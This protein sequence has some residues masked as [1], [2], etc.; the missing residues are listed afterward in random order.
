MN[1][2]GFEVLDSSPEGEE[3]RGAASALRLRGAQITLAAIAVGALLAGGIA[4]FAIAHQAKRQSAPKVPV[5]L[6]G[7][8]IPADVSTSDDSGPKVDGAGVIDMVD[9]ALINS[10]ASP[11]KNLSITWDDVHQAFTHPDEGRT[12]LQDLAPNAPQ[13]VR[14]LLRQPCTT[15][16]QP[17]ARA[18]PTVVINAS[19]PTGRTTTTT[20]TPLGLDKVWSAMASA[21]P[22]VD[23][24]P[25][26]TVQLSRAEPVGRNATDFTLSFVNPA[27]AD[28]LVRDVRL[29][30]G[31]NSSRPQSPVELQVFPHFSAQLTIRLRIS[32]CRSAIEDVSASTVTFV[33]ASAHD[34][35]H[36]RQVVAHNTSYA[37][38]IGQLLAKACLTNVLPPAK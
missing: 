29:V 22:T 13:A 31:L 24:N 17:G 27:S 21:C 19:D 2:P 35:S 12:T 32:D 7:A 4:G 33:V 28:V 15:P 16:A 34:P 23:P 30:K 18:V 5:S 37:K 8:V 38:A 6:S 1:E 10:T 36:G 9:L 3:D 25:L 11:L 26:T 20:I 14:L